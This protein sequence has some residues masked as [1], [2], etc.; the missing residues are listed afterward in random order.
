MT[1]G[2]DTDWG[3]RDL[4]NARNYAKGAP[5]MALPGFDTMHR[6]TAQV[7]AES[8]QKDG[9]ILVLGGGGGLEVGALAKHP[10]NW[11]ITAVDPSP[12]MIQAAQET[13]GDV[14]KRVEWITGLIDDASMG[15]FDGAICLLTLHIIPDNG[16]KLAT[17][18]AIHDRLK[19]GARFVVVDNC[20][21]DDA[22]RPLRALRYKTFF[23]ESGAPSDAVETFT[24]T[25]LESMHM[26][27]PERE[28][29]LL[30]EAGFS[31][32]DLIFAGFAWRGWAAI[33]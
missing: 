27:T 2:K 24:A 1:T 12:E 9:R 31:D 29:N 19:P 23:K 33:A 6:I 21:P 16:E 10:N 7:L 18:K 3:F 28:A 4:E 32:I 17:L 22:L 25:M 15:P 26:V 20:L 14:A 8:A 5:R 11:S 13:L 30:Q